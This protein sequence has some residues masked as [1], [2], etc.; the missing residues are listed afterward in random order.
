[1]LGTGIISRYFF[2]GL[3]F[4]ILTRNSWHGAGY[5]IV[6]ALMTVTA[7]VTAWGHFG[8]DI[9]GNR[10][11][12]HAMHPDNDPTT[13]FVKDLFLANWFITLG[14]IL[15]IFALV[16]LVLEVIRPPAPSWWKRRKRHLANSAPAG[17]PSSSSS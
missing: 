1:M 3:V 11:L 7:L 17:K 8:L 2:Y 6:V 13:R 5:Y 10:N 14:T 15:N 4:V 16:R 9:L 12:E